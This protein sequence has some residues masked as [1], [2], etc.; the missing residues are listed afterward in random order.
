MSGVDTTCTTQ[1]TL[2]MLVTN[3]LA[4]G[5]VVKVQIRSG[6]GGMQGVL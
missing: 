4:I 1:L 3:L 2:E 5:L 6:R